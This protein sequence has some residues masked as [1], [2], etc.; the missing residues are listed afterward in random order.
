MDY[1][2]E[3]AFSSAVANAFTAWKERG[4]GRDTSFFLPT[5]GC[6]FNPLGVHKLHGLESLV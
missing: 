1:R 5:E 6:K 4:N 2:K 3:I